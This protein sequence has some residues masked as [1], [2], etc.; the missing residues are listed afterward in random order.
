MADGF[1]DAVL[2]QAPPCT[3]YV[4]PGP[5]N[6][7]TL[8]LRIIESVPESRSL[9]SVHRRTASSSFSFRLRTRRPGNLLAWLAGRNGHPAAPELTRPRSLL[10]KSGHVQPGF[11]RL[12]VIQRRELL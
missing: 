11:P 8:I 6:A 10:G 12:G 4:S 1:D 2:G 9:G 5:G 7:Q 3:F